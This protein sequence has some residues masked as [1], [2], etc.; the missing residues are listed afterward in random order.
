LYYIVLLVSPGFTILQILN[1]LIMKKMILLAVLALVLGP[2]ST[3]LSAQSAFGLNFNVASPQGDYAENV[4]R[5]MGMTVNF[6]KNNQKIKGLYYGVEVGVAMYAADK[7]EHDFNGKTIELN[8]E[9]CYLSYSAV[10]RY[11]FRNQKILSPY[12]EGRAGGISYFSTLMSNDQDFDDQNKFYGSTFSYGFGGG[13]AISLCEQISLDLGLTKAFGLDTNYR[14]VEK[15]APADL[16]G[17]LDAGIKSSRTDFL[18]FKIGV[19]FGF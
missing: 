1:L 6:L 12:V 7:Y 5:P 8:E 15:T 16:K 2:F 18:N 9:D 19:L 10:M 14:S 17:D 3:M 4:T 13:V 11:H